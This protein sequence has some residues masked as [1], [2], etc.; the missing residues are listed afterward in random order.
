MSKEIPAVVE[1]AT[2]PA[3]A[4]VRAA[5]SSLREAE[6]QLEKHTKKAEA[7]RGAVESRRRDLGLA[8]IEA[9]K[10]WPAR[11]PNAKGWGEFLGRE[12][13]EQSTAWRLMRD[14]GAKDE[15][16]LDPDAEGKPD[17]PGAE[18]GGFM[19]THENSA[20]DSTAS[21]SARTIATPRA[22]QLL[23]GFD[24]RFGDW[25]SVLY[26]VGTVDALITDPP[27]GVATHNGA[28][29]TREDGS[30]T[31]GLGPD[32]AHWTRDDVIAFVTA[33]SPRVRGWMAC[34]TSHDLIP[35]WRDAY[36]AVDRYAFAPVPIVIRGMSNRL[37]GDGPSSWAVYLMVARPR[38]TA[39]SRWGTLPGAYVHAANPDASKGR[40]KPRA[41]LDEI[42]RDYSRQGDLVCDPLAGWG[43]TLF[44]A[45][46][47]DR[48][49]VGAE[50][51]PKAH[52]I[53]TSNARHPIGA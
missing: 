4:A 14:A 16:Q 12:G 13:I 9:R 34:M 32:Y 20:P 11:G 53:A 45:L 25:Q 15:S 48:R 43:S 2:A 44:A 42:V 24:L 8:L 27:F 3:E 29:S 52:E 51:D 40:G 50:R 46:G 28:K 49:A 39:F 30:P 41:L 47:L 18:P 7:A 38:S 1:T 17:L 36:E 10:A 19:Q 21:S 5:Y 23:D 31:D 22:M 37:V 35:A 33:W 26:D 6:V